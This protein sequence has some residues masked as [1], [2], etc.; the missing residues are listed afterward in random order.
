MSAINND[1]NIRGLE[2]PESCRLNVIRD[3]V[4]RF[5]LCWEAYPEQAVVAVPDTNRN[6]RRVRRKIREIG[7]SLELYGTPEPW[8]KNVSPGDD[9]C[10]GVR[11]ALKEIAEWIL[12]R[13]QRKCTFQ[14]ETEP[15][16]LHYSP[17]RKNRP[18]VCVTIQILHRNN[19]DQPIDEC[20]ESCLNEMECVLHVLGACKGAW[21]PLLCKPIDVGSRFEKNGCPPE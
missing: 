11:S 8:A 12:P 20:E 4:Q 18:D 17:V 14:I 1:Q 21:R 15:Q 2:G 7:F 13:E 5:A 6:E 3:L 10:R 19:W 16:S 9:D